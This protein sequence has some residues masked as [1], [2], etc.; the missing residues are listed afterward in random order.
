MPVRTI[1]RASS[2]SL[3]ACRN[4]LR[5]ALLSPFAQAAF[6]FLMCRAAVSACATISAAP[7]KLPF[8]FVSM[9][10]THPRDCL[11]ARKQDGSGDPLPS[12]CAHFE[13]IAMRFTFVSACGSF[14]MVT[15]STPFLNAAEILS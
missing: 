7:A 8:R 3:I 5:A 1:A 6:S 15:V 4:D 2:S 10:G 13:L 9:A 11:L 14:D 12:I